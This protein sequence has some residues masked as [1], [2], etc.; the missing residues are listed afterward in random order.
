[1]P[2]YGKDESDSCSE[3]SADEEDFMNRTVALGRLPQA[4]KNRGSHLRK[5]MIVAIVCSNAEGERMGGQAFWLAKIVK[6]TAH[7]ITLWYYGDKFQ[8]TVF[9]AA[10][11]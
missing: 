1:M 11:R 3:C 9:A 6:L 4:H 8:K 7:H 5:D 2:E 10:Q